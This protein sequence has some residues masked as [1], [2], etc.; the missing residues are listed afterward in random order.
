MPYHIKRD[1]KF[2]CMDFSNYRKWYNKRQSFVTVSSARNMTLVNCC[3][4]C[5]EKLIKLNAIRE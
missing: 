5:K 3:G 2:I 1:G 4:A